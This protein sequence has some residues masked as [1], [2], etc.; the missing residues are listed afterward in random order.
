M[1]SCPGP[2]KLLVLTP[3][4]PWPPTSG[5]DI[6]VYHLLRRLSRCFEIHLLPRWHGDRDELI[7]ETGV[8]AVHE[9]DGRQRGSLASRLRKR[10]DFWRGAPH[11]ISLD[12]DLAYSTA[13]QRLVTTTRFDAVLIDH[14]FMMQYARFVRPSPVFYSATDVETTK[15]MRWYVHE[16]ISLRR[17]VLHWA[18]Q[19]IIRRFEARVGQLA[20]TVFATSQVDRDFLERMN[21]GGRFVVA[22]NGVDLDY[23]QLRSRDSFNQPPAILFVGTLFYKPNL[24]AI[25][26]LLSEVFPRVRREIPDATCHVV[27]KTIEH[28][29]EE[30]HQPEAGV[31]VHGSVPDVRPY[32]DRCQVSV[33]PLFIGSGTR[34]KIVEA[35]A[36]GTPVVATSVGAEGLNYTEGENILI[37]NSADE[38]AFAIVSL[39]RDRDRGARIG[40]AGRRLIERE[41]TWDASAEVIRSEIARVL[42]NDAV[43]PAA[44]T[45]G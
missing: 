41:Y 9:R 32:L 19:T 7:R 37:G 24:Q 16:A 6:R 34:I 30:L 29:F 8:A 22:A 27:G 10:I 23:F 40:A 36:S 11:E 43:T 38:L 25:T 26:F 12:L 33:V 1:S 5:G 42:G 3:S 45:G 4:F 13:L 21:K 14:L 31:H 18:Q 20:R 28:S 39:L 17:R 15:F 2:P 44:A 35:M